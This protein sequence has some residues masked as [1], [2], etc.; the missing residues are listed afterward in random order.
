MRRRLAG[1]LVVLIVAVGLVVMSGALD[2]RARFS[3][4]LPGGENHSSIGVE[5]RDATGLVT[6]IEPGSPPG[7]EGFD[8]RAGGTVENAPEE[9]SVLVMRW[10]G[11]A[12]DDRV[13]MAFER[14]ESAYVLAMHTDTGFDLG[15][16][17]MGVARTV[18]IDLSTAIDARDVTIARR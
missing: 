18:V 17:A 10:L 16:I 6:A 12:C 1:L 8:F 4:Q 2:P 9:A 14:V 3:V 15:C 5:L 7:P 11:G 13:D